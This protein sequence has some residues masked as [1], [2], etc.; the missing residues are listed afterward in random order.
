MERPRSSFFVNQAGTLAIV[1]DYLDQ[2]APTSS[3]QVI[4]PDNKE[5]PRSS[6]SSF[7]FV[8]RAR[9][10]EANSD[11]DPIPVRNV[12]LTGP[13]V[14]YQP[15]APARTPVVGRN[16]KMPGLEFL[17]PCPRAASWAAY[18]G[19]EAKRACPNPSESFKEVMSITRTS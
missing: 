16:T 7:L 3:L 1:P 12:A 17:A 11:G 2:P 4:V 18:W 9:R 8:L 5:L 13:A 6:T 15:L 10:P 14:G 19:N